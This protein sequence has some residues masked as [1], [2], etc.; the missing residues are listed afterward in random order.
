MI[1]PFL[2]YFLIHAKALMTE[3][4]SIGKIAIAIKTPLTFLEVR[5]IKYAVGIPKIIQTSVHIKDTLIVL[6]KILR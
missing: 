6:T 5:E 1:I 3:L 4:V 2:L